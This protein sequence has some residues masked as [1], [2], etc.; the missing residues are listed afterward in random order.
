M[1]DNYQ[2]LRRAIKHLP[3]DNQVWFAA[4]YSLKDAKIDIQK[5]FD[6]LKTLEDRM[7]NVVK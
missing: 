5:L 2:G 4:N 1:S 7:N 6:N 3:Y